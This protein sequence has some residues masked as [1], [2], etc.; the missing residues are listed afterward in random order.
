[1]VY[2]MSGSSSRITPAATRATPARMRAQ[3]RRSIGAERRIRLEP[4]MATSCFDGTLQRS[5]RGNE[6]RRHPGC[7][8]R[9]DGKGEGSYSPLFTVRLL[10]WPQRAAGSRCDYGVAVSASAMSHCCMSCRS[11]GLRGFASDSSLLLSVA[12]TEAIVVDCG[13]A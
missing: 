7:C 4:D 9:L 11:A 10:R 1:P 12:A 5:C 3:L 8:H 2:S 13:A 6:V